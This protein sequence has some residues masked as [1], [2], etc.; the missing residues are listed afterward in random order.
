[1]SLP[2]LRG[3]GAAPPL[4]QNSA[5]YRDQI[6]KAFT[7]IPELPPPYRQRAEQLRRRYEQRYG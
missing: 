6:E 7:C 4:G 5:G 1:V 3:S 2:F